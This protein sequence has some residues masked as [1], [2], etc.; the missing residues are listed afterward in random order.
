M[1][2]LIILFCLLFALISC[3]LMQEE[4]VTE[5]IVNEADLEIVKCHVLKLDTIS[6]AGVWV[7]IDLTDQ[8]Q[9]N[10]SWVVL[11]IVNESTTT[12]I[13]S[14]YRNIYQDTSGM[15]S[16]IVTPLNSTGYKH[17]FVTSHNIVQIYIS[18]A[19]IP[20]KVYLYS[21]MKY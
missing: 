2:T 6:T 1:K 5:T 20:Y 14:R 21:Y 15:E 18:G 7:N 17:I 13:S 10:E 16:E 19:S 9:G 12:Q 4:K 8:L 11:E 3:D